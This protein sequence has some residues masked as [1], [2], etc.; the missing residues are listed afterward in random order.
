M[1]QLLTYLKDNRL[2]WGVIAVYT[3]E[4]SCNTDSKYVEEFVYKQDIVNDD[5]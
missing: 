5:Q 3:C 2:D 4:N 1:P